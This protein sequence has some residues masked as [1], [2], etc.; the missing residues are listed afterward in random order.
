LSPRPV[1]RAMLERSH[2]RAYV[3][4]L[5]TGEPRA[6]AETQGFAWDQGIWAMVESS[7]G[8][9]V[10]AARAAIESGGISGSLSSGLHHARAAYGSAFCTVNGLVIAAREA[11]RR[12]MGARRVLILDLDGH[13][14]GGTA[15]MIM[16]DPRIVQVDVSTCVFDD[17]PSTSQARL[18]KATPRTYL[19]MVDQALG[20]VGT[21][22]DLCLYNAGMDADVSPSVL[23]RRESLV[24]DWCRAKQIP[25][26]FVLAGGYTWRQSQATDREQARQLR[27]EIADRN[28]EHAPEWYLMLNESEMID[29]ASGFVPSTVRAMA[30]FSL[31]QHN[32][33]RRRASR[34]ARTKGRRPV[35]EG[36]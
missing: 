28:M 3:T 13:C 6:L 36:D 35:V 32:E 24:F 26:A 10:E 31:D 16:N 11:L 15:S 7:T 33:D 4:A 14:G 1:T 5:M 21:S 18:S 29:I 9:V 27:V 19:R 34:P 22:F 17:Y 20:R 30:L 23:E 8:G 25:V 12:S 2:D